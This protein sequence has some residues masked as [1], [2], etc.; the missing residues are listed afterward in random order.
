MLEFLKQRAA[1]AHE[2]ERLHAPESGYDVPA[3]IDGAI[4]V[5]VTQP[6]FNQM[7]SGRLHALSA[8]QCEPTLQKLGY[9]G[10]RVSAQVILYASGWAEPLVMDELIWAVEVEGVQP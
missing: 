10:V 5:P 4:T 2:R 8:A 9:H 7:L 6:E 3:E 1:A